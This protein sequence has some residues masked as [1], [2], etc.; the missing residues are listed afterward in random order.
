MIARVN[1]EEH[2]T[3]RFCGLTVVLE[4]DF[5]EDDIEPILNAIKMIKGVL[6]VTG[7]VSNVDV[8]IAQERARRE[9]ERKLLEVI[10]PKFKDDLL[11]KS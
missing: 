10:L 4:Q 6:N 3:D 5:R 1:I 8:L 11:G 2:M 7:V 9:L